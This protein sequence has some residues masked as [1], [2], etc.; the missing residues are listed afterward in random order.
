MAHLSARLSDQ[1]G[2]RT[3]SYFYIRR[4][5]VAFSDLRTQLY[6]QRDGVAKKIQQN[7]FLS[8]Q[9]LM[10][11]GVV[12]QLKKPFMSGNTDMSLSFFNQPRR[13]F[14]MGDW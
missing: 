5:N 11:T 2:R 6:G 1:D 8:S 4:D 14:V 13:K 9:I 10:C 12:L 7:L 3:N